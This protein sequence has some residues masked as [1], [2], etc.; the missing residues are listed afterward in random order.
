MLASGRVVSPAIAFCPLMA[1][2]TSTLRTTRPLPVRLDRTDAVCY[3][4]LPR[5]QSLPSKSLPEIREVARGQDAWQTHFAIIEEPAEKSLGITP[6]APAF[7]VLPG[8]FQ[9]LLMFSDEAP[10]SYLNAVARS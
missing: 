2:S 5:P 8:Q 1:S 9:L 7:F 3:G 6:R 10:L 4:R